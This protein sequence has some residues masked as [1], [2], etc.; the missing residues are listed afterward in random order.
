MRSAEGDPSLS[1]DVV[2]H[3]AVNLWE[4]QHERVGRM[5]IQ[6]YSAAYRNSSRKR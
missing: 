4:G 1:T 3:W 6:V 5:V 2:G